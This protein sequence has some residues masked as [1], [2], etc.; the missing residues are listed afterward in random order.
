M[1]VTNNSVEE[2]I[3][4]TPTDDE[5]NNQ[6]EQIADE[7]EETPYKEGWQVKGKRIISIESMTNQVRQAIWQDI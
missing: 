4:N 6:N 2:D 5:G 1:D 7:K 3:D